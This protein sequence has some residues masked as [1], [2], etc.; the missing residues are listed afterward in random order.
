MKGI[1]TSDLH[2][3]FRAFPRIENG[4]FAREQDVERA[5]AD[6]VRLVVD[7]QPDLVTIAGDV[8]HNGRPSIHAI[9]AF[10]DGIRC[11][12][13]E[14]NAHVVVIG[15]NHESPKTAESLSPNVLV[16]DEV[17]GRVF[18]VQSPE[19]LRMRVHSGETVAVACFPFV[20]LASEEVYQLEPDPTADVNVLLVHAA[21]RSTA[22]GADALPFFYGGNVALD[23]GREAD[24]WDVIACGDYHDFRR[25]HPTRLAFYSGSIERT[26]SNIWAEEPKCIVFYDTETELL[27]QLG[28][29]TRPVFDFTVQDV[30]GYEIV[31]QCAEAVNA[32]MRMLIDDGSDGSP[33]GPFPIDDAIVRLVVEDFDR[34]ERNAIDQDLKRRLKEKCF[35][36]QL[37]IRFAASESTSAPDRRAQRAR[38]IADEA[39]VFFADD[40]AEVRELA[41]EYMVAAVIGGDA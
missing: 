3:G 33:N 28:I 30:N 24:R 25:L 6:T 26:S 38:T 22:D 1:A 8:F 29:E 11:I 16:E 34:A 39:V 4:R 12:L 27:D 41:D 23:V 21:V 2:L 40:P 7:E 14:T 31:P 9:K 32:A 35:H 20:T 19:R 37:D 10:Q 36:F 17:I 18:V 5:W 15:G 13:R